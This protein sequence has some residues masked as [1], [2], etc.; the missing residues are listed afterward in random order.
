MMPSTTVGISDACF[1]KGFVLRG[2][3]V[4]RSIQAYL[5]HPGPRSSDV[6]YLPSRS[7]GEGLTRVPVLGSDIFQ[8]DHQ[9]I[10]S[11]MSKAIVDAY[12]CY[13]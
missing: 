7:D 5:G 8:P 13:C 6:W 3:E 4:Q 1:V 9:T 2:R 11:N 10:S 12:Y